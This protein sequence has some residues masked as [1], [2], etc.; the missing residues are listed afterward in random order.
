MAQRPTLATVVDEVQGKSLVL[1]DDP[2]FLDATARNFNWTDLPIKDMATSNAST[3][4]I[5]QGFDILEGHGPIPN[6]EN[7]YRVIHDGTPL[8][9][10]F[11]MAIPLPSAHVQYVL[12]AQEDKW[13]FIKHF[14]F[15]QR[16]PIRRVAEFCVGQLW[17]LDMRKVLANRYV[18][19]IVQRVLVNLGGSGIFNRD[20]VEVE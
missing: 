10:P 1:L 14:V 5:T 19:L 6:I 12:V 7:A 8:E 18:G 20:V 16:A 3:S 15:K 13:F 17:M 9:P 4:H 2:V 11:A